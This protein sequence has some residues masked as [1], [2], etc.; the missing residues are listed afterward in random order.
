[1]IWKKIVNL[2]KLEQRCSAN[3][4]FIDKKTKQD[5]GTC[6]IGYVAQVDE[7]G[8]MLASGMIQ[9]PDCDMIFVDQNGVSNG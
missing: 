4:H 6:L 3:V 2:K 5:Y 8:D 7:N 9:W 1:M